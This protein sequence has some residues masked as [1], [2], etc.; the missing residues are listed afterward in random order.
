[1]GLLNH[2]LFFKLDD[3]NAGNG[4]CFMFMFNVYG[5]RY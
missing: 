1:M 3:Y 4:S 2:H 5:L